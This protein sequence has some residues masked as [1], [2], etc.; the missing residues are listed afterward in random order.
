MIQIEKLDAP[1][2]AHNHA[3]LVDTSV[4]N[5]FRELIQYCTLHSTLKGPCTKLKIKAYFSKIIR[6]CV[7]KWYDNNVL[8]V[9]SVGFCRLEKNFKIAHVVGSKLSFSRDYFFCQRQ[10][11]SVR[12]KN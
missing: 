1:L 6:T 3:I 2:I 8:D 11:G 10:Q 7:A 9:A 5:F 12:A 4:K